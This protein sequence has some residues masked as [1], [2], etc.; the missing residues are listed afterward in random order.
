MFGLRMM[1]FSAVTYLLPLITISSQAPLT[2]KT[3][4]KK[5][6]QWAKSSMEKHHKSK[7]HLP[8]RSKVCHADLHPRP[9]VDCAED[10]LIDQDSSSADDGDL[11]TLIFHWSQ[12]KRPTTCDDA[13]L[14][15]RGS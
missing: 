2:I 5:E 11:I 3:I 1:S 12:T 14:L 4:M 8:L 9:D 13:T 15:M 7:G 6:M 10:E